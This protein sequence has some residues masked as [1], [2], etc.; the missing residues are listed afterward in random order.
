[1]GDVKL[2]ALLGL[3]LGASVAPALAIAL[4]SGVLTGVVVMAR[5]EP[6][7]R[8]GAGI[9]F[10]PFLALGGVAAIFFRHAIVSC[11]PAPPDLN[12]LMRSSANGR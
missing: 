12:F 4:V 11:V 5:R 7:Q 10:G 8:R 3:L 2:A 6:A 1:M 9:P